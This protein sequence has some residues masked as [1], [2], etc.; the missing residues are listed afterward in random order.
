MYPSLQ[1]TRNLIAR[2]IHSPRGRE[3]MA[4]KMTPSLRRFRDYSAVGRLSALVEDVED[5]ALPLYDKDPYVPAYAVG[6]AGDSIEQLVT[7]ERV[8]CPMFELAALPMIPFS[9]IRERR[10]DL[11]KRT[12][13]L[14]VAGIRENEDVRVFATMDALAS[15]SDNPHPDIQVGAPI[16]ADTIADCIA[17]IAQHGMRCV[18]IYINGRDYA[19]FLKFDRDVLDPET[20]QALL[21]T[22]Y[23]GKVYGCQV[24]QSR[25]VPAGTLYFCG[26]R[27]YFARM[28]IRTEL[29]VVSADMPWSRMVG[30]SAWEMI[31]FITYNF[32]SFQ[33]A[34]IM[35]N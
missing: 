19:D 8:F 2:H 10:Y 13:E 4:S 22:G 27:E 15:D 30:F 14:A 28:P 35:R 23:L 12:I 20:Q 26:E 11:I 16:T 31:G 7:A 18:R 9:Q 5:G 34:L 25:V 17:M 32:L 24:I 21:R 1:A 3:T 33:R 6:E 29:T